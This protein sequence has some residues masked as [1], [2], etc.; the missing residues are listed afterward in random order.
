MEVDLDAV[1]E[2]GQRVLARRGA[3]AGEVVADLGGVGPE[4]TNTSIATTTTA[5]R[6]TL[7]RR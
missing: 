3:A 5:S 4:K 1:D 6:V 2:F 7:P